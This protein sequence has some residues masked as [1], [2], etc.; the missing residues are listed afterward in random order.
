MEV[1]VRILAVAAALALSLLLGGCPEQDCMSHCP[2]RR[3]LICG[4]DDITYNNSCYA[5]C[6]GEDVQYA[7]P[8]TGLPEGGEEQ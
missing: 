1:A 5:T 2:D 7:G 8:C 6:A 3:Q 4:T